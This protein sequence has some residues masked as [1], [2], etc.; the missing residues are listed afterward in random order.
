MSQ[1][2]YILAV[3]S[4]IIAFFLIYYL[5]EANYYKEKSRISDIKSKKCEA[6]YMKTALERND[7]SRHNEEVVDILLELLSSS[8]LMSKDLKDDRI[9]HFLGYGWE[10]K[11]KD[12]IKVI[13]G[14]DSYGQYLRLD[15]FGR[16]FYKRVEA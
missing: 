11:I 15:C 2:M 10:F 16:R 12:N 9:V 14:K 5:K 4:P 8:D 7:L 6:L 3:I 13:K 1:T